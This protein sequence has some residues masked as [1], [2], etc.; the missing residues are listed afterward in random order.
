[1]SNGNGAAAPAYS[2]ARINA[3]VKEIEAQ[4]DAMATRAANLA[5]AVS[6]RDERI[7]DLL[8]A[9]AERDAE[10]GRLKAGASAMADAAM[11]PAAE[12]PAEKARR[13]RRV[14]D[15]PIPTQ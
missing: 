2:A 15:A 4:R 1:M 14:P 5:G 3:M 10:I 7:G 6:D 8:A 13:V 12:P 11:P 9:V